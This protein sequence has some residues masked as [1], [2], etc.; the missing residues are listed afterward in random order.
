MALL[1]CGMPMSGHTRSYVSFKSN[2]SI[3]TVNVVACLMQRKH[4]KD[5]ARAKMCAPPFSSVLIGYH[6]SCRLMSGIR[7]RCTVLIALM[8]S[9]KEAR[10]TIPPDLCEIQMKSCAR[11]PLV[12]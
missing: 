1:R 4:Q 3:A 12:D 11:G 5:S 7:E 10:V 6:G 8:S 2:Q 9:Q